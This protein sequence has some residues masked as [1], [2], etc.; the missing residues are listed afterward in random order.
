LSVAGAINGSP[1]AEEPTG[2]AL[3]FPRGEDSACAEAQRT[4]TADLRRA[5]RLRWLMAH[6]LPEQPRYFSLAAFTPAEEI[7]PPLRP[8]A[9][10]LARIDP[11]NDG[12]LPFFD[13]VIPGAVLLGYANADHGSIVT[14]PAGMNAALAG[15][16]SEL[17]SFPREVLI[18]AALLH[19][20][21]A[22]AD[23]G[24]SP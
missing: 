20:A 12:L 3:L 14:E 22:L 2:L 1:L 6:P 15:T 7:S 21:E 24:V 18:E 11:R 13:Q 16:R 10:A 19:I 8:R 23:R 17:P 5:H 9:T 4:A